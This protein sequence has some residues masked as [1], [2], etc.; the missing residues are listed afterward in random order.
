MPGPDPSS[1]LG[2]PPTHLSVIQRLSKGSPEEQ[3]G[4]ADRVAEAYWK[5][6][7]RYLRIGCRL[8][9]DDAQ[10]LT[11]DFLAHALFRATLAAFDPSKG[12]FR[13]YLRVCL[14][15]FAVN[16][17]KAAHRLKRGGGLTAVPLDVEGGESGLAGALP[18]G[19]PE[20]CFRREW[21]RSLFEDALAELRRRLESRD[22][23]AH[24]EAFVAYDL[25]AAPEGERP[26]YASVGRRVGLSPTQVTNAL[27]ATRNTFRSIV[28]DRLREL[29]GSPEEF[30]RE[31]AEVL[32]LAVE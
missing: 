11:Q 16:A 23:R 13:T 20:E 2:F 1:P 14:D 6:I 15:R 7:Y 4:A 31:A 10:D 19:D 8:S 26:T 29:T 22:Q 32:G 27:F 25:E 30:V 24:Y 9:H 21:I 17:H 28:L 5:P 18:A 12:R 3:A